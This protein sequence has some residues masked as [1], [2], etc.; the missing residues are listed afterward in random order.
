[1]KIRKLTKAACLALHCLGS[2]QDSNEPGRLDSKTPHSSTAWHASGPNTAMLGPLVSGQSDN[3]PRG[4]APKAFQHG[5]STGITSACHYPLKAQHNSN[6]KMHRLASLQHTAKGPK[7]GTDGTAACTNVRQVVTVALKMQM[8]PCHVIGDSTTSQQMP[9][10]HQQK[11][12]DA[13]KQA[14]AANIGIQTCQMGCTCAPGGRHPPNDTDGQGHMGSTMRCAD[15]DKGRTGLQHEHDNSTAGS[16]LN[17]S[18]PYRHG[19]N[20]M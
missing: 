11:H 10:Q 8:H 13:S 9:P 3:S 16:R 12:T 17:I 15:T 20:G 6:I 7:Q 18:N 4:K 14:A 1:M 5:P 2:L 19:V